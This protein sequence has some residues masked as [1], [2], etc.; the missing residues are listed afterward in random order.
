MFSGANGS[1]P[2]PGHC[3][4]RPS[5]RGLTQVQTTG[6]SEAW[7]SDT[8]PS[9]IKLWREVLPRRQAAWMYRVEVVV[10]RGTLL[11]VS[12]GVLRKWRG[13]SLNFLC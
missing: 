7:G 4:A 11:K 6:V 3:S 10:D 5:P 2:A 13:E 8:T 1:R 9:E 12:G